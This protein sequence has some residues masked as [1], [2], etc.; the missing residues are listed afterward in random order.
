VFALNACAPASAPPTPTPVPLSAPAGGLEHVRIGL[1]PTVTGA[2]VYLAIE[3]G[4]FAAAGVEVEIVPFS[5]GADQISSLASSQ[6]DIG[7]ADAGAGLL[8]AI[9]RD[10]PMR[11]VADGSQCSEKHCPASLVVRKELIDSGQVKEP[12]DLRGKNVNIGVP[13]STLYQYIQ[14]VL[15]L[16]GLTAADVVQQ[17]VSLADQVAA[18]ASQKL[19]ASWEIEPLTT[20]MVNQGTVVRWHDMYDLF[21]PQQN[22]VIIYAPTFASQRPDAGRRFM[23]GYLRGV[24]DYIDAFQNGKDLDGVIAVLTKYTTIKDP[25]TFKQMEAPS[26]DPNGLILIDTLKV[27]QQWYVEH[28][29]M[30]T[31]VD[32]EQIYDTS[33]A[34]YALSVIGRR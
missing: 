2:G 32:L 21:G 14:R 24:R 28:G 7:N 22:T 12:A 16:G 3:R 13:G 29:D 9:A 34:D 17:N 11:F 10:L 23:V 27:N 19:D 6:I 33:F 31:P 25:A 26:M 18:Y 1:G 8:N 4:Y 5:G 20:Q 30:Q 15:A